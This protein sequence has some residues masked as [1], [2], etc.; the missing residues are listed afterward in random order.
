MRKLLTFILLLTFTLLAKEPICS[1]RAKLSQ[2]D[3]FNSRG[4]EIDKA[5]GVIMQD[6]ANYFRFKKQ[7]EEDTKDCIFKTK[8]ARVSIKKLF[9]RGNISNKIKDIILNSTPTVEIDVY[10]RYLKVNILDDGE[11]YVS[12][13]NNKDAKKNYKHKKTKAKTSENEICYSY[14]PS[15]FTAERIN[16]K[17]K[18]RTLKK[19]D[20]DEFIIYLNKDHIKDIYVYVTLDRVTFDKWLD[21]KDD[22]DIRKKRYINYTSE[23]GTGAIKLNI[24]NRN[25]KMKFLAFGDE[26]IDILAKIKAKRPNSVIKGKRVKCPDF[27]KNYL[28]KI[29]MGISEDYYICRS[30]VDRCENYNYSFKTFGRGYKNGKEWEEAF[31]KCNK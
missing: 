29:N 15:N 18:D 2:M 21:Y 3:H 23:Y 14:E 27:K 4:D 31:R 16:P 26:E 17:D 5:Y 6:R 11:E 1:Y 8:K 10:K 9:K 20:V 24:K 28:C 25:I 12:S 30:F 13:D 22:V 7:D 19:A